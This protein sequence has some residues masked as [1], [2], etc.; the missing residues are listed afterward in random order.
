[1]GACLGRDHQVVQQG[2]VEADL[3]PGRPGQGKTALDFKTTLKHLTVDWTFNSIL[4][5]TAAE[6]ESS[7]DIAAQ[8]PSVTVIENSSLEV[9]G[10]ENKPEVI[11]REDIDLLVLQTLF[12][13]RFLVDK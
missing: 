7:F 11:S 13:T 5:L 3:D 1:M 8:V 10:L 12:L 6:N 9:L 2:S 4:E